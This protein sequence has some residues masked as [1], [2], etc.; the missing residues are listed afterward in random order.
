MERNI[1]LLFGSTLKIGRPH[2]F[3]DVT[4]DGKVAGRLIFELY[5]DVVPKTVENFR[6][7]CTGEKGIS[8]SGKPLHYKGCI[9]HRIIPKFL[10]QGGDI[11]GENGD[12]NE[13]IYGGKFSD[14][15]FIEKHT[16]PGVLSMANSG[17]NTN[18]SQFS[19]MTFKTEWLD[20]KS[21]V[22]GKLINGMDVLKK[23]EA[24][25]SPIGTP[26]S[27]CVIENCGQL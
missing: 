9:F 8:K 3:L 12:G 19:I 7:L 2:V 10:V 20:G 25:G 23:I 18:G 13:S 17:P 5:S 1:L 27:R 16:G 21:V 14:E 22:F 4:I 24:Q 26:K 6:C 15:N 11:T